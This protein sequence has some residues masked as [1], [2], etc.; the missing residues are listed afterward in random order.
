MATITIKDIA[1][2]PLALVTVKLDNNDGFEIYLPKQL[3][4]LL[5]G[6][7]SDKILTRDN[8]ARII[9]GV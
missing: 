3:A 2:S 8:V 4:D 5:T 7:N 1:G 6:V 9:S